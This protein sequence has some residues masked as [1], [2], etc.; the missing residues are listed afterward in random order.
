VQLSTVFIQLQ[1]AVYKVFL[2]FHAAYN[3]G[4]LIFFIFLLYWKV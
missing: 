3:Q 1:A 2:S 4:R